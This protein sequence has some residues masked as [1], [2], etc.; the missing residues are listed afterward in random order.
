MANS[1]C[2]LQLDA[3]IHLWRKYTIFI[4][5]KNIKH[6]FFYYLHKLLTLLVYYYY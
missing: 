2:R 4:L 1:I 6:Y 5:I 3:F